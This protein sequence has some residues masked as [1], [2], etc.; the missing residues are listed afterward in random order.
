[1]LESTLL[2]KTNNS[3]NKANQMVSWMFLDKGLVFTEYRQKIAQKKYDITNNS[4]FYEPILRKIEKIRD[5]VL[6]I[7]KETTLESNSFYQRES[8]RPNE[9]SIANSLE[10]VAI[11]TADIPRYAT[12]VALSKVEVYGSKKEFFPEIEKICKDA[13]QIYSKELHTRW[14]IEVKL[15]GE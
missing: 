4:I 5:K 14:N 15:V 2:E 3:I 7:T 9:L 8:Y 6:G 11:I 13:E 1:M 10:S 12:K